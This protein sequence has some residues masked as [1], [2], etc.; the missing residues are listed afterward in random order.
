MGPIREPF[1]VAVWMREDY[2]ICLHVYSG[3]SK[4]VNLDI[5]PL[6]NVRCP[7]PTRRIWRLS[8]LPTHRTH[9]D[10]G[11]I[12]LHVVEV[13][14]SVREQGYNST[15]EIHYL[16]VELPDSDSDSSLEWWVQPGVGDRFIN[17]R[18]Y[19]HEKAMAYN[20]LWSPGKGKVAFWKYNCSH[21]QFECREVS[22][23]LFRPP[24]HTKAQYSAGFS[25]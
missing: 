25:R 4:Y 1:A 24:G 15:F 17:L 19:S 13:T 2:A 10:V 18:V 21:D 22:L 8:H 7:D 6:A 11:T 3:K 16:S 23:T 14:H 20:L 5:S 12:R 9:D